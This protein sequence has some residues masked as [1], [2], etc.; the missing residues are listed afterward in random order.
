MRK[1]LKTQ[2]SARAVTLCLLVFGATGVTFGQASTTPDS[3]VD[4]I[5]R[6]LEMDRHR[7][8][9]DLIAGDDTV[10]TDFWTDGCSGGLST[11]W[12][13]M[14]SLLPA[15]A[16]RHGERPPW[17][18]CCVVHDRAYHSGGGKG[19]SAA[20]SFDQRKEADLELM[21][22]VIASGEARSTE[23]QKEYGL[24]EAQVAL[25]YEAIGGCGSAAFP[26]RRKPGVGAT[27]GPSAVEQ[28][29]GTYAAAAQERSLRRVRYCA[30]R[31]APRAS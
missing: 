18:Q 2:C 21:L 6:R 8:L 28:R 5:E 30:P 14:A 13:Y 15:F 29:I 10:K 31:R 26:A 1:R 27:A 16:A 22:C 7:Q 12:E 20:E 11:G 25:L 24:S 4:A 19:V 17:E 23:L 9:V 3:A